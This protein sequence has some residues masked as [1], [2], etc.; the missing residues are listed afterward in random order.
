MSDTNVKQVQG[1]IRNNIIALF[2]I[3]KMPEDK[4]EEAI[5]QVGQ[6]IF[7][8]VLMRIL[9]GMSEEDLN[10]YEKMLEDQVDPE[11]LFEFFIE[12]EPN[13][14][15]IVAEES[16]KFAKESEEVLGNVVE[17]KKEE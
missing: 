12:K 16:E 15:Q 5:N 11:K 13:F 17:E 6:L 14:M 3:D 1:D 9:P 7:Q 4:Q 10:T 2:G 8:S